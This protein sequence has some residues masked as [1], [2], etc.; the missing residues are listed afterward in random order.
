M[1]AFFKDSK[2]RTADFNAGDTGYVPSAFGHH[3]KNTGDTD[4]IYLEMFKADWC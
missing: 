2:A 4:L 1:T 3:I